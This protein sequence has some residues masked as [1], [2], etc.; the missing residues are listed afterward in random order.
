MGW[1]KKLGNKHRERI[2]NNLKE[3]TAPIYIFGA[4]ANGIYAYNYLISKGLK[5]SGFI[6]NN[7]QIWD[8][9]IVHDVYCMNPKLIEK[10]SFIVMGMKDEYM[11]D[12]LK[13]IREINGIY[14]GTINMGY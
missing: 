3:Q 1:Q 12:I 14:I 5:V 9:R 13:Q 11:Q 6:D 8:K 10:D 7:S 4:G 2:I